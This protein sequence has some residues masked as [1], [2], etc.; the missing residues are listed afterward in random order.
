MTIC[1]VPRA[2]ADDITDGQW[3]VYDLQLATAHRLSTGKGVIV[4]VVDTG[5]DATHPALK[6]SVLRGADFSA[7]DLVSHGDGGI[8]VDGHGTAMAGLVAGHGRIMGVAPAAKILPVRVAR[9][10][11]AGR[12]NDAA[13]I[14]WAVDHGAR[15]INVSSGAL[16]ADPR[17]AYAIEQA[18]AKDIVVVAGAGNE[19][20]S[21][22]VAYP[23]H[24]SG[25]I[26]VAATTK[27]RKAAAV[28][29]AGPEI[30]LCAPGEHI[31]SSR[32]RH[33]YAVATGTSDSTALVSG[34]AA[35]VRSRFPQMSAREV[36]RRLTATAIDL[37]PKGRDD[38]FG[39]GLVDPVAA[40]SATVPPAPDATASAAVG[41]T[42]QPTTSSSGEQQ[43]QGR[44]LIIVGGL[45]LLLLALVAAGLVVA[46]VATR[47]GAG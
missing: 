26:A 29:V 2:W 10:Q 37:G 39:Y 4:A 40:L 34:V 1:D 13:A 30:V 17:E 47:R 7:S 31:S 18:L 22:A 45:G 33:G 8:D 36:V 38:Q 11:G 21:S 6:E 32:L 43:A 12:T 41:N 9:D 28:S 46:L 23:A 19:P 44:G 16:L 27:S 42:G 5:V 14:L 15:V 3:Y 20:E 25:V 24:Y 35:L